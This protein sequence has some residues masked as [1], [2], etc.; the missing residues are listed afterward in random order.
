MC[1]EED[2]DDTDDYDLQTEVKKAPLVPWRNLPQA[3]R[4][5]KHDWT[6]VSVIGGP[7][8]QIL[9]VRYFIGQAVDG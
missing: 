1:D 8:Y 2:L 3:V 9:T 7:A 5:R 4:R 6:N